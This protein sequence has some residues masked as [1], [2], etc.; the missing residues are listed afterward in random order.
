MGNAASLC[1]EWQHD[2]TLFRDWAL[3]QDYR[4]G[5]RLERHDPNGDFTPA[6][7]YFTEVIRRTSRS[8]LLTYLGDTKTLAEWARDPRNAVSPA[9][10][11]Q[12]IANGWTLEDALYVTQLRISQPSAITAFN[13]TRTV[14]AWAKDPRCQVSR[15]TLQSRLRAGWDAEAALTTPSKT[16]RPRTRGLR[17]NVEAE[18][19]AAPAPA[20][21]P[22]PI[23]VTKTHTPPVAS[24]SLN[25]APVP[26]CPGKHTCRGPQHRVTA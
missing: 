11:L 8:H 23:P 9:A 6:N 3:A 17:V 4:E 16:T 12:R 15:Q 21:A 24:P 10:F 13:E 26:L 1:L 7:C 19:A 5:Q 18:T 2:Y 14:H 22:A 25:A 20:P